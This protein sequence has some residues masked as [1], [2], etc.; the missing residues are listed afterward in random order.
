MY[1]AENR[2]RIAMRRNTR[3]MDS[4]RRKPVKVL[5]ACPG[6]TGIQQAEDVFVAKTD[7][8]ELQ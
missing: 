2:R 7:P 1:N 3:I 4:L 6:H 5:E 8:Q